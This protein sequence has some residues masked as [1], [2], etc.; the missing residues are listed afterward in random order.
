MFFLLVANT[1]S[2]LPALWYTARGAKIADQNI[3]AT[4]STAS[5]TTVRVCG[6]HRS[7]YYEIGESGLRRA[8]RT[9]GKST[10]ASCRRKIPG[11]RLLQYS[12]A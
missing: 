4:L 3:I 12:A 1:W 5:R 9:T 6:N 8:A 7:D 11:A 10:Y 2:S